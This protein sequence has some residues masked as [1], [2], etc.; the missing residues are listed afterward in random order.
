[1]SPRTTIRRAAPVA[2]GLALLGAGAGAL[3]ASAESYGVK[4]TLRA[5]QEVPKPTGVPRSATG[6]FTG[7]LKT[8]AKPTLSWKLTFKGL[9]GAA[10]QAH[11]HLGKKGVSGSVA[12][13]LC[14]PCRSGVKGTAKIT[15]KVADAIE[16]GGAYVN[17][18]TARNPA[19]EIRGQIAVKE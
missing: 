4:A 1:M 5:G 3:A 9:S 6:S 7:T 11:V 15:R 18:H 17:V 13:P 2:A 8:G 12:I 14:G 16:S 10:A 19:G